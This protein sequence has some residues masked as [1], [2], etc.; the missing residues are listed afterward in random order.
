MPCLPDQEQT[1][2]RDKHPVTIILV[3]DPLAKQVGQAVGIQVSQEGNGAAA[4]KQAPQH[5]AES[6]RSLQGRDCI[7]DHRVDHARRVLA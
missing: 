2:Q 3:Y 5:Q 1:D 6:S 7:H 4:G